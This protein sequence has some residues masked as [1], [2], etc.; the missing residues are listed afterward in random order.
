MAAGGTQQ[1]PTPEKLRLLPASCPWDGHAPPQPPPQPQGHTWSR[2]K[3]R[4]GHWPL[5]ALPPPAHGAGARGAVGPAGSA[6]QGG[7]AGPWSTTTTTPHGRSCQGEGLLHP[8]SLLRPTQTWVQRDAGTY[9]FWKTPS[10]RLSD[11]DE[12]AAAWRG[13]AQMRRV[14]GVARAPCDLFIMR[15]EELGS[16]QLSPVSSEATRPPHPDGQK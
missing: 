7:R 2:Q 3:S 6:G 9:V 14:L 8:R 12:A 10:V 13:P 16:G 1:R 11:S 4:E 5:K 15:S